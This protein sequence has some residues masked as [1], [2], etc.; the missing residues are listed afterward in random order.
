MQLKVVLDSELLV[1]SKEGVFHYLTWS[2]HK[3]SL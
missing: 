1:Y 2:I 3:F